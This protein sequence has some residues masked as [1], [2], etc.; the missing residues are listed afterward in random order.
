MIANIFTT[1]DGHVTASARRRQ[2][3]RSI[4]GSYVEVATPQPLWH[5]R[6]DL[7]CML[8]SLPCIVGFLQIRFFD[9]PIFADSRPLAS[10]QSMHLL[11]ENFTPLP[12]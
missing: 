5:S 7:Y 8:S 11:E 3:S 6:H 10:V 2:H 12:P 9:L 1:P 4:H